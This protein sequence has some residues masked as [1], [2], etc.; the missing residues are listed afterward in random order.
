MFELALFATFCHPTHVEIP[1]REETMNTDFIL[2][3][4]MIVIFSC[5]FML[6][7][8]ERKDSY[9]KAYRHG[10]NIGKKVGSKYER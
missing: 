2:Y 4:C 8:W 7:R 10:F 5:G 1:Q 9:S 6:G 3:I